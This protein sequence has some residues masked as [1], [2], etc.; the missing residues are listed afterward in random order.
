MSRRQKS[1][2]VDS[3]NSSNE[4]LNSTSLFENTPQKA[5]KRDENL[6]APILETVKHEV[7]LPIQ[8]LESQLWPY[9]RCEDGRC[10]AAE[11]RHF[12][13]SVFFTELLL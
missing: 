7:A 5:F 8:V 3:K 2:G 11:K 1:S 12:D 4:V 10:R 9:C 13:E 6:T